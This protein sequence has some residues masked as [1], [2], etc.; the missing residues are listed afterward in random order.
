MNRDGADACSR[1]KRD[2]QRRLV[3]RRDPDARDDASSLGRRHG[4]VGV[5][6]VWVGAE[7]DRERA[8]CALE[9]AGR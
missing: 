8:A 2:A 3:G 6:E 1:M 9:V 5:E 4:L 7:P